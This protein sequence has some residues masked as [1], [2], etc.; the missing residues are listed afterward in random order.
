MAKKRKAKLSTKI[1][2]IREA[3]AN[4]V[5]SEGCS[6][7]RNEEEHDEARSRLGK[8]LHVPKYADGSGYDFCRYATVSG[9]GP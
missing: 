6:C 9:G 1:A 2:S 3:F 4:Y 5:V 7:C 8:L